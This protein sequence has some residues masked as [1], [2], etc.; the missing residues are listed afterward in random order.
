MQ[1]ELGRG[2]GSASELE[3]SGEVVARGEALRCEPVQA[4][5][6]LARPAKGAELGRGASSRL[7]LA[8]K[9][10]LGQWELRGEVWR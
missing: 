1:G 5:G 8:R 9:W 3:L 4:V 7:G 6:G 10:G 2:G